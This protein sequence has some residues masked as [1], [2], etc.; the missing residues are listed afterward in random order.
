MKTLRSRDKISPKGKE[1]WL[2]KQ[3]YPTL[4]Q[5]SKIGPKIGHFMK[6]NQFE[7][8]RT[9]ARFLKTVQSAKKIHILMIL[10][11]IIFY[12]Y[13]RFLFLFRIFHIFHFFFFVCFVFDFFL[14]FF[15]GFLRFFTDFSPIFRLQNSSELTFLTWL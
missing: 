2:Q 15:W 1:V 5:N 12:Y 3:K 7:I 11:W 14:L 8:S 9:K 13:P 6:N 4:G 10:I